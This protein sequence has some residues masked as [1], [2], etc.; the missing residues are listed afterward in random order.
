MKGSAQGRRGLGRVGERRGSNPRLVHPTF[1]VFPL[2]GTPPLAPPPVTIGRGSVAG[3]LVDLE[4]SSPRLYLRRSGGPP[5]ASREPASRINLTPDLVKSIA[6]C[7]S[8][9]G[10]DPPRLVTKSAR[11]RRHVGYSSRARW[12]VNPRSFVFQPHLSRTLTWTHGGG[13]RSGALP[14]SPHPPLPSLH[15][16][17]TLSR[18]SWEAALSAGSGQ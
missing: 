4:S 12:G 17:A 11:E 3:P 8:T 6:V 5:C 7:S 13:C 18:A 15:D 16:P 10:C 9:D 14:L 2:D 1:V